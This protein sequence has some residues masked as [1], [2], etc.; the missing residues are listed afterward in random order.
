M[1]DI[2]GTNTYLLRLIY[3]LL[4]LEYK[5][6]RY[7]FFERVTTNMDTE[8]IEKYRIDAGR[9]YWITARK[10]I[11]ESEKYTKEIK[12][13]YLKPNIANTIG[14]NPSLW[15]EEDAKI[16]E[17]EI[18]KAI[19]RFLDKKDSIPIIKK[20]IIQK[21]NLPSSKE[22]KQELNE[23]EQNLLNELKEGKVKTFNRILHDNMKLSQEMLLKMIY[24]AYELGYYQ[25][26]VDNIIPQLNKS[27]QLKTDIL[28]IEANALGSHQL[29][30][31]K[32]ASLILESINTKD[33][34]LYID[35]KTAMT[36]NLLRHFIGDNI[37]NLTKNEL[38]D[39]LYSQSKNYKYLFHKDETYDYYPAINYA[40][41]I[42]L[43]NNLY[44]NDEKFKKLHTVT[45]K[46]L[47]NLSKDSITKHKES[48]ELDLNYYASITELEFILLRNVNVYEK[49]ENYLVKKQHDIILVGRTLRQII[50]FRD[51]LEYSVDEVSFDIK[52]L[53]R[54][55]GMM[56][57]YISFES[58]EG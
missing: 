48:K 23:E 7:Q 22:P 46:E 16:Q 50:F 33:N 39:I 15:D 3:N 20:L 51:V 12:D 11:V 19:K 4:S 13:N 28:L 38:R 21:L 6:T 53:N 55:I 40:Y 54:V 24:L 45:L 42:V 41:M 5:M 37:E 17:E 27:N 56:E 49:I 8:L 25:P 32:E 43:A 30:K 1:N 57:G 35:I 26:L 36:S 9:N 52:R 18:K 14:F 31:H 2:E 29:K 58:E 44:P 47:E 10:T 34:L